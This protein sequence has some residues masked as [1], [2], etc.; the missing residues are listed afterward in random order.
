VINSDKLVQKYE[1]CIDYEVINM[2]KIKIGFVILS[3]VVFGLAVL[4]V[5]GAGFAG[6]GFFM[7]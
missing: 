3:I 2:N 1:F 7:D 6:S 5:N 4:A